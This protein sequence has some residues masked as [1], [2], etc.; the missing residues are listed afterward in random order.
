VTTEA[1]VVNASPLILYARIDQLD[2][3]EQLAPR[4]IIPE[5]VIAE[6]R[7]GNSKDHTAG[8]AVAWATQYRYPDI[9]IPATVDRWNLGV[10]ESQMIS[11]CLKGPRCAARC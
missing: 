6:V 10:G 7:S 2:L 3:L 4:L 8:R 11:Y 9:A 1:W 5:A